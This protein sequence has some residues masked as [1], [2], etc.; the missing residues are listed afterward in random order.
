L[1]FTI[2]K[3]VQALSCCLYR[4]GVICFAG[5]LF[6]FLVSSCA[7]Q[8]GVNYFP[9]IKDETI[10]N[11]MP[12]PEPTIQI[13]DILS[14][15]VTSSN[16]EASAIF[17]APN[18]STNITNAA[19]T[20][21]NTLTIG[22][23]VNVNGDISFPVLGQIHVLG[24]TKFHLTTML[25]D[26]ILEKKLLIDPIVTIRY[27][28]F[29]VSVMGE[30]ARPG[31]FTTP[32][33]KLSIME[34][35]SFAGDITIYGE[36]NDVLLI[37]ENDKGEKIVKHLDLTNQSILSSPYYYLKSNDVLIVSSNGGRLAKEKNSQTIPIFFA[38]LSFLIVAIS[39]IKFN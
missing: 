7:T 30:V 4:S 33:E 22:Y 19:A 38:V 28:N 32:T 37:R 10:A 27:L 39:Q 12:V 16:P 25:T 21:I 3:T 34:A 23:L 24:M 20:S 6:I 14:I 35:L 5:I 9:E 13:N 29:K 15:I 11:K 18:E 1:I 26:K 31:V 8:K 2:F 36:K 17:N